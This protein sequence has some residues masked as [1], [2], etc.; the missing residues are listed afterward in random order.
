MVLQVT[1]VGRKQLM[2]GPFS[3]VRGRNGCAYSAGMLSI[4][5]CENIINETRNLSAENPN[6]RVARFGLRTSTGP[7]RRH[8]LVYHHDNWVS[9]CDELGILIKSQQEAGEHQHDE[10]RPFP[11]KP[12]TNENFVDAI[13][14]FIVG[15]DM[16]FSFS[17]SSQS[18][19]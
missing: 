11:R 13:L 19:Y 4:V 16:V 3:S 2:S 8:L 12:Y 1:D 6:H 15:D 9:T 17:P 18:V 5:S 10:S 7:L 14:E